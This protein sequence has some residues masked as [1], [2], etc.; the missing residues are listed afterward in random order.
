M[1][2]LF[3][4][5]RNCH[6]LVRTAM[7]VAVVVVAGGAPAHAAAPKH[8][9]TTLLYMLTAKDADYADKLAQCDRLTIDQYKKRGVRVIEKTPDD[10]AAWVEH[11]GK[12]YAK[13]TL[14]FQQV[15]FARALGADAIGGLIAWNL[16]KEDGAGQPGGIEPGVYFHSWGM[17]L[18]GIYRNNVFELNNGDKVQAIPLRLAAHADDPWTIATSVTSAAC[19]A[20]DDGP[21][22]PGGRP[23][24]GI[25]LAES[26]ITSVSKNSPAEKA[27]LKKGD[28]L[29]SI[30][31][32]LADSVNALV[33]ILKDKKVGD[34]LDVVYVRGGKKANTKLT[35]ADRA[36]VEAL[37]SLVGKPLPD[38]VG[39]DIHGKEVRL[40][41][42]RGKIVVLDFWATWCPPC[43]EGSP[44][45]QL[46]WEHAKKHHKDFVWLGVSVDEDEQAWKNFVKDNHLG[47][48]QII[49]PEWAQS[50]QIGSFPTVLLVDR[51]GVVR[52]DLDDATIAPATMAMLNAK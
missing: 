29:K 41:D 23:F 51:S 2:R 49:S 28:E 47:G 17:T 8:R 43:V 39:K 31:G 37:N 3:T 13:A 27:G 25:G 14:G 15:A 24:I 6:L 18:G 30:D 48:T 20:G 33:D 1:S 40:H 34:V 22:T 7:L 9:G 26:R 12:D 52:C 42:L 38:P 50:M 36:A 5:D 32:R 4:E 11:H 44:I 45:M 46:L 19:S 16:T 10:L 21:R 35:L